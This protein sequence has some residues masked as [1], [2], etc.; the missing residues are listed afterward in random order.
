MSEKLREVSIVFLRRDD[1]I[2]LAM[3]KRGFGAGKWNGAGGKPDPDIDSNI[4]DT[5]IRECH[6][7]IEVTPRRLGKVAIINF[8]FPEEKAKLGFNQQAHIFFCHEWMGE[9][10]ESE[11]MKPQWF[12]EDQIPYDEMWSDDIHWLPRILAGE[13]IEADFYFDDDDQVIN[14]EIRQ[15]I[16]F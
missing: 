3:K 9:P 4:E 15:L 13:K 5:A 10:V 6:E 14:Y 16:D 11:E 7:E 12:S 1:S 2:L 8:F